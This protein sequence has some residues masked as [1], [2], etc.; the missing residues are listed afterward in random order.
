MDEDVVAQP[1][2]TGLHRHVTVP[3]GI[4]GRVR[5]QSRSVVEIDASR[6]VHREPVAD[7]RIGLISDVVVEDLWAPG[8]WRRGYALGVVEEGANDVRVEMDRHWRSG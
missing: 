2:Q 8:G 7:L 1:E 5:E 6:A 4:D 3:T